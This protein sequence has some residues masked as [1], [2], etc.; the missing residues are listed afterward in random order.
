VGDTVMLLAFMFPGVQLYDAAPAGT[1]SVTGLPEH[2]LVGPEIAAGGNVVVKVLMV[3]FGTALPHWSIKVLPSVPFLMVSWYWLVTTMAGLMVKRIC[4]VAVPQPIPAAAVMVTPV[5]AV[6][7]CSKKSDPSG[8]MLLH[9]MGSLSCTVIVVLLHGV[10]KLVAWGG[11]LS[12][13]VAVDEL[14]LIV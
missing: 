9:K 12:K 13:I 10:I 8:R 7:F 3:G 1:L 4:D 11:I 14:K 2:T 5:P 6:K